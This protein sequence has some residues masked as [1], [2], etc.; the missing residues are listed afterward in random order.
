MVCVSSPESHNIKAGVMYRGEY[1]LIGIELSMFSRK[2]EA[3]L[4]FQ[5][6]PWRWQYKTQE[7]TG[8]IEQ[9]V[10]SHFIPALETPDNWVIGDT[11]ALGPMLNERFFNAP[12]IPETPVQR[13]LCFILEDFFNHW[14]GRTCVHSRWCYPDNVSWVGVRMGVNSALNRSIE[15]PITDAE[16]EQLAG[17]GAMMHASFG[18]P[19]CDNLGVGPTQAQAVQ[20]DFKHLLAVLCEHFTQQPFLLGTRPCLADFALAGASKAHFITDPEPR[21][22]LGEQA[23]ALTAYTERVFS[24]ATSNCQWLPAD[25]L[26][27]SLQPLLDYAEATYYPYT[28]ASISAGMQGEKYFE[29]DFGYGATRARTQRRLEKARLHVGDE[30]LQGRNADAGLLRQ[31]LQRDT[32]TDFYLAERS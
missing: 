20:A 29:Y 9:R 18:G 27:V 11:I 1:K 17:L 4:R 8:A 31:V 21:S 25:A 10:G 30:L 7:L 5:Q 16:E 3:Q 19:V 13:G 26:P 12:V 15:E 14:L 24:A 32:I 28:S 6:I 23:G 2:L 22:W